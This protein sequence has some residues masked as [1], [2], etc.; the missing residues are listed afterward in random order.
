MQ[1][2]VQIGGLTLKNPVMMAPLCGITDHAFRVQVQA[3]G[4]SLTHPE[5]L[6]SAALAR[7]GKKTLTLL[8]IGP[9]EGP[10]GVQLFGA[11]PE[12]MAEAARVVAGRG[13]ALVGINF[14]C[15]VP[16]V[17]AHNGGS[18]LLKEPQTVFRIV[19]AVVKAVDLP[20]VPKIRI[21]WDAQNVNALEVARLIEDA[22]AQALMVHGRTRAQ[23]YTG[24]AD[25]GV[26]AQV[27]QALR[28]PVIGN[29]DLFAAEDIERRMRESGVDGVLLARGALGNPWLFSRGLAL[30][31]GRPMPPEPGLAERVAAFRQHLQMAVADKGPWAVVEMRKH[32]MWYFKGLPNSAHLRNELNQTEDCARV[33]ELL[34]AYTHRELA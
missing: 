3:Q 22:G 20:V 5:M 26:I 2:P 1:N 4:A 16:K 28:I 27:K 25:W 34:E 32:A 11:N 30:L 10:V 33:L 7:G 6:S 12:E 13:A 23:R 31:E 15:P 17:V 21:G 14:G 18:A 9:D 29:G 24:E 19:S 8:D